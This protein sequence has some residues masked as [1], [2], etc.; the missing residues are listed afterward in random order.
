MELGDDLSRPAADAAR[1]AGDS[2]NPEEAR[3]YVPRTLRSELRHQQRLPPDQAARIGFGLAGALAHLLA[4]GLVHRDIKPS[5]IIFVGGQ[6]KLAD[7]GLVTGAGDSRSF[8]GT[9]GFI[10]PEGPG[11]QQ[12]DLYGLGKLL[13]ELATG[14]DRLEFPQL[15]QDISVSTDGESLLELNEVVTR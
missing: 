7:I 1:P 4:Q 15:P 11:T 8:V 13:Y 5:N 12:A 10:P 14:R 3:A 6:P 9:E 2:L